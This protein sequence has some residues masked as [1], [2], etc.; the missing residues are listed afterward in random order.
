MEEKTIYIVECFVITGRGII[1]ELQHFE[2]G[3]P[4]GTLIKC[5]T[6]G[7]TWL[8][9]HRILFFHTGDMQQKFENET[10]EYSSFHFGNAE[11]RAI[12]AKKIIERSK[13]YF[14]IL[15]DTNWTT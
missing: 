8:I 11:P 14:S 10:T 13:S 4:K 2:E 3:L 1:A 15:L 7:N 5:K 9:K 6:T 12:S